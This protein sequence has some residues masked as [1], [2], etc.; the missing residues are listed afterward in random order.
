MTY[1]KFC[2]H[3]EFGI[4][5]K[6]RLIIADRSTN[7]FVRKEIINELETMEIFFQGEYE[8]NNLRYK[9]QSIM[10]GKWKDCTKYQRVFK[11]QHVDFSPNID[12]NNINS[13]KEEV[14]KLVKLNS[15]ETIIYFKE[16]LKNFYYYLLPSPNHSK[17]H[18]VRLYL[19]LIPREVICKSNVA[20]HSFTII[21]LLTDYIESYLNSAVSII[22]EELSTSWYRDA[23]EK[24]SCEDCSNL[25][26]KT[27]AL[28]AKG[29]IASQHNRRAAFESYN[30]ALDIGSEFISAFHLLDPIPTYYFQIKN[31]SSTFKVIKEVETKSTDLSA[32]YKESTNI[33]FST[34][35]NY[36]QMYAANWANANFYFKSV[37][38]NF[39][40]VTNDKNQFEHCVD[41]YMSILKGISKLLDTSMPENFRFYWIHSD[42]I[43]KTVYACA[44]FYLADYLINKFEQNIFISDIDQL[45]IGDLED[46]FKKLSNIRNSEAKVYQP[47]SPGFFSVLP[48]RS[49]LAGNIF[50][51]NSIDGKKYCR[52]L[53]DYVEMGL[54]DRFSWILDQ[55]ATRYASEIITV[56]NLDSYGQRVLKQY[57][58]LKIKL[59]NCIK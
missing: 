44:R 41:S 8:L 42:V 13:N 48:G 11:P 3:S 25:G 24:K 57:P 46:Y 35:I 10:E 18:K 7:T 51:K 33:C 30:K 52:I 39:G 29:H 34:D 16:L 23:L 28:V 2:P 27:G 9:Y 49:H 14:Y 20:A 43:N 6:V 15:S 19:K 5:D 38:F 22:T 17:I 12:F 32:Y 26:F 37:I 50:I 53:T 59:K 54:N 4:K 55:N 47:I 31:N 56:D 40:I 58:S 1:R 45:V 36:F 21:T